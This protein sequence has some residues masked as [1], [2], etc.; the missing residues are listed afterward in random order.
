MRYFLEYYRRARAQPPLS[1]QTLDDEWDTSNSRAVLKPELIDAAKSLGFK[2]IDDARGRRVEC[3][4]LQS[5][6]QPEKRLARSQS[7]QDV[8]SAKKDLLGPWKTQQEK[9]EF[10]KEHGGKPEALYYDEVG[11]DIMVRWIAWARI[12]YL[13][14]V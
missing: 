4:Y 1:I 12:S 9:S 3:E 10:F 13:L 6:R 14:S 7:C 8:R 11:W 2:M 5:A